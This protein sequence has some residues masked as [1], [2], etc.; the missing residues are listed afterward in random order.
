MLKK[1]TKRLLEARLGLGLSQE[2]LGTRLGVSGAAVGKWEKTGNIS[3]TNLNAFAK[4]LKK[5]ISYFFEE[6][7]P[8]PVPGA[9]HPVMVPVLGRIPAGFPATVEEEIVEYISLPNA[10]PGSYA[11]VVKGDSMSPAIRD[12]DYILFKSDTE[13]KSGDVVVINDEW[14]ETMLKRYKK[15]GNKILFI[16][17]NPE[18]PHIEPNDGY[19]IIGKVIKAWRAIN[20]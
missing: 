4:I 18:Y 13:I 16:S 5:P 17:D 8:P 20:F 7:E 2:A 15:K 11:L 12:G 14:N 1:S 3:A 19:K 10:P 6:D 9:F